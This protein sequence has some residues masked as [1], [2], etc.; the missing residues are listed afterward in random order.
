MAAISAIIC[1]HPVS[2]S[3]TQFRVNGLM[4]DDDMNDTNDTNDDTNDGIIY[5]L[6][7]GPV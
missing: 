7:S 5:T 1:M 4:M 6:E 2:L 3:F